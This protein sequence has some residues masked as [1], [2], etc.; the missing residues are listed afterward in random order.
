[1]TPSMGARGTGRLITAASA[2]SILTTPGEAS[3]AASEHGVLGYL[4]AVRAE[5][6]L[7]PVRFSVIMPAAVD[8]GLAAVTGTV[9]RNC[10]RPRTLR[11]R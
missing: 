5:L 6:H 3:Y 4:K 7:S 8:A 11:R 9:R 1:M 10:C 2:A